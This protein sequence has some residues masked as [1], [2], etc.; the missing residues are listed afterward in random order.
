MMG[1]SGNR[2]SRATDADAF[3]RRSCSTKSEM[4]IRFHRIM[5]FS[6]GPQLRT[7]AFSNN[8]A[9]LEADAFM[10]RCS[11]ICL[12]GKEADA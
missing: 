7:P 10:S 11:L 6:G 1:K 3:A 12:R 9:V 8:F 2:P 4:M 5:L